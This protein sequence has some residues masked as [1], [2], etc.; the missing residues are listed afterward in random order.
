MSPRTDSASGASGPGAK[1]SGR[2]QHEL[3]FAG[4][5]VFALDGTNADFRRR[6]S[7]HNTTHTHIYIYIYI[8]TYIHIYIYIH[9]RRRSCASWIQ[10]RFS[11]YV[12]QSREANVTAWKSNMED[13]TYRENWLQDDLLPFENRTGRMRPFTEKKMEGSSSNSLVGERDAGIFWPKNAYFETF[14]E[15]LKP[16]LIQSLRRVLGPCAPDLWGVVLAST[17]KEWHP[18]CYVLKQ[19]LDSKLELTAKI[20]DNSEMQ[21]DHFQ[22]VVQA[23]LD[24]AARVDVMNFETSDATAKPHL[25]DVAPENEPQSSPAKGRVIRK[26]ESNE[27]GSSFDFGGGMLSRARSLA[28]AKAKA[29]KKVPGAGGCA[30]VTPKL[31]GKKDGAPSAGGWMQRQKQVRKQQ[32]SEKVFLDAHPAV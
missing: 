10:W 23:S 11:H 2:G 5:H 20:G 17:L 19:R 29:K 8:H 4:H 16:K 7:E 26:T 27:S 30:D 24:S 22:D 15:E 6:T 1:L 12:D 14:H 18:D 21:Q 9:T 32:A 31:K 13:D 25:P 3:W 28:K